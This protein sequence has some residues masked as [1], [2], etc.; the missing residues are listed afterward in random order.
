MLSIFGL[1]VSV[2]SVEV[3]VV[4][5]TLDDAD[6]DEEAT[7]CDAGG[8]NV[9]FSSDDDEFSIDVD[10]FRFDLNDCGGDSGGVVDEDELG[11]VVV[12][13]FIV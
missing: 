1:G 8:V 12:T 9:R 3:D 10:D 13:T 4:C 2:I 7:F 11:G 6:T 5:F